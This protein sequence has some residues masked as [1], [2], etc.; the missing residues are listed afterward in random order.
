[1][2]VVDI[3]DE[4]FK[5][6]FTFAQ[7]PS[8]TTNA[9]WKSLFPKERGFFTHPELAP[10]ASTFA[11]FH[12]LHCLVRFMITLML[13]PVWTTDF[14]HSQDM[15]R[16]AYYTIHEASED[17]ANQHHHRNQAQTPNHK[18][19]RSAE[20]HDHD[21]LLP[22]IQHC[23]DYLRKSIMCNADL[24][25]EVRNDTLEGV[26]GF[27]TVHRCVDYQNLLDWVKLHE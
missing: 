1:M 18:A 6:N 26:T 24:T 8:D 7:A 27:G 2:L 21:F 5:P 14:G 17:G 20:E 3:L 22:H 12:Q 4:L 19:R 10:H 15:V 13:M 11:V 25:I 16:H 9:A 23:I